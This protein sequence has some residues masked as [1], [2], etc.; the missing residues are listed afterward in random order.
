MKIQWYG[1]E[2]TGKEGY[3]I[4]IVKAVIADSIIVKQKL[5]RNYSKDII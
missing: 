1:A 5:S 2:Y 4:E 3:R